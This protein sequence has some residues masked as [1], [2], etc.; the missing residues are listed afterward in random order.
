MITHLSTLF[1]KEARLER[2]EFSK[3][4]F[5]TKMADGEPVGEHVLKLLS[6]HGTLIK[7]GVEIKNELMCDIIL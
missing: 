4:L 6:Y 1:K 3:K 7:L 5:G 2:H